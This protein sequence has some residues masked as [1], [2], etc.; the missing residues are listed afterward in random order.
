MAVQAGVSLS[1]ILFL[2]GAGYTGTI[3]L[4]NGKLSDLIGEL[5]AVVR[6]LEKSGDQSNDSDDV[7]AQMH[8]LAMEIR[9]LT[10]APQITVLNGDSSGKL[11]YI[12]IPAAALGALGYAYMWWKGMSLP[13]LLWVTNSTMQ[14]AVQNFSKQLDSLSGAVSAAKNYLTKRI[15][16]LDDKTEILQETLESVQESVHEA[17][18]S[19]SN[20]QNGLENIQGRLSGLDGRL[21]SIEYK[22]DVCNAGLMFLCNLAG[23]E[24]AKM[25][26]ALQLEHNHSER[27]RNLLTHPGTPALKGLKD[28]GEILFGTTNDSG[29]NATVQRLYLVE[30]PISPQGCD[31]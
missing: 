30:E 18:M 22:Q 1:R 17:G 13:D 20:I 29:R 10:S 2:A 26:K 21:S 16:N 19:L 9:Q 11:T 8:R 24:K 12:V 31:S 4:K 7:A 6:G 14:I 23:G 3:L 28:V 5:Q 25:F 15:D 27:S